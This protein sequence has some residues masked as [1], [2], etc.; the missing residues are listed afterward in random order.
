MFVKQIRSVSIAG[1]YCRAVTGDWLFPCSRYSAMNQFSNKHRA[2]TQQP[3]KSTTF[4]LSS[5]LSKAFILFFS[6]FFFYYILFFLFFSFYVFVMIKLWKKSVAAVYRL[7]SGVSVFAVQLWKKTPTK[8]CSYDH[9]LLKQGKF[10]LRKIHCRLKCCTCV[11]N[12]DNDH[13]RL[14]FQLRAWIHIILWGSNQA[15]VFW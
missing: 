2:C 11:Q 7:T 8:S 15:P 9:L 4:P 12:T 13:C 3:S 5:F 6:V 14:S 1:V 10:D